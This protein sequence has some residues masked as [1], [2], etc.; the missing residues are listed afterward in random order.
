[1][2]RIVLFRVICFR[3]F[4]QENFDSKAYKYYNIIEVNIFRQY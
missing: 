2:G 4:F 1:M 3:D